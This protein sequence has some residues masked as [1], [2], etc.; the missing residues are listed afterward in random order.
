MTNEE[1]KGEP[2]KSPARIIKNVDAK[3]CGCRI[4][5]YSD[6]VKMI[7]PCVPCG[8]NA[9]AEA[10]HAAAQQFAGAMATAA[11]ALAATATTIRQAHN[12]AA[13]EAAVARGVGPRG[14]VT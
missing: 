1:S 2:A 7:A 13:V 3:P 9:A 5:E 12:Q 4:T 6:G 11:Q 14:L 10:M 8:L